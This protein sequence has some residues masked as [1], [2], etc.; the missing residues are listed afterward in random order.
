[1]GKRD[2]GDSAKQINFGII[3]RF[4]EFSQIN[5][6]EL[7]KPEHAC[8]PVRRCHPARMH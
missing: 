5:I 7:T 4:G 3:Y 2:K 1:M 6:R 8:F